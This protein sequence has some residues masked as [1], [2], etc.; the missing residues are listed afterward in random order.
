[1]PGS[2]KTIL[3]AD[4]NDRVAELLTHVFARHDWSVTTY[5]AGERADQAL[6]GP[7][8]YDA[9]LLGHRFEGM[10]GV[11]LIQRI[12]ALD[13]RKD[14]P[15]VLVTGTTTC[16]VVAAALAAGAD[17][18]VYKPADVDLLVATVTKCVEQRRHRMR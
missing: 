13:H 5:T 10:D 11:Q 17:E 6:R 15:I 3:I 2:L 12:R 18:V 16:E 7:D 8:H 9:V 4:G 1:M 14:V